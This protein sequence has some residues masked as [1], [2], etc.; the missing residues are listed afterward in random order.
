MK[1][2]TFNKVLNP[3]LNLAE[4]EV[5]NKFVNGFQNFLLVKMKEDPSK[6]E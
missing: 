5:V 4:D 3:L 6:I 1:S 2:N